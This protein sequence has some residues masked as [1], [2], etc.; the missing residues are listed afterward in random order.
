MG[1]MLYMYS[2]CKEHKVNLTVEV[3]MEHC[4]FPS[5]FWCSPLCFFFF[6]LAST[7]LLPEVLRSRARNLSNSLQLGF[8]PDD[9]LGSPPR[10]HSHTRPC[11]TLLVRRL[12]TPPGPPLCTTV[13]LSPPTPRKDVS[14]L[15]I[16]LTSSGLQN[17]F[18]IHCNCKPTFCD[19]IWISASTLSFAFQVVP[20][21][22]I[23]L[24]PSS[25]PLSCLFSLYN[26]MPL[27]QLIV[28][29]IQLFLFKLLCGFSLLIGSWLIQ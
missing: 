5:G 14:Y 25:I 10:S 9:C 23:L 6:F 4:R 1:W 7:V 17:F 2:L 12:P 8:Q 15:L 29:Y 26:F 16:G 3:L 19:K 27:L 24:E 28:L 11:N 22:S 13:G 21:L 20:H 18:T